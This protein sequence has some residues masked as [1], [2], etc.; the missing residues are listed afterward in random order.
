KARRPVPTIAPDTLCQYVA[1]IFE[2][3]GAPA[4]DAQVIA[5]HLVEA[6]QM[7]HDSHG[8]IRVER[9]VRDIAGGR[10]KPGVETR[11]ERDGDATAVVDGGWNF[12][13]IVAER[14]MAIAIEKA[15][16]AGVG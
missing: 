8:V 5:S 13:Q 1:R 6:N 3:A 4:Q 9:Y 7:G 10:I 14:T 2:G 15:R 16:T 11:I 12:G